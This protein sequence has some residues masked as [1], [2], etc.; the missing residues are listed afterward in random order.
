MMDLAGN[1]PDTS[2]NLT[3]PAE[4]AT[5]KLRLDHIFNVGLISSCCRS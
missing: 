5:L 4:Y 1:I 2:V 3:V